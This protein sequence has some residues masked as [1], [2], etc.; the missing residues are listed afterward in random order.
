MSA[1]IGANITEKQREYHR[2]K[3]RTRL[4]RLDVNN[5]GKVNAK[6]FELISDRIITLGKLN[7]AQ[8]KKI[9]DGLENSKWASYM[10]F[11][12]GIALTA[13]QCSDFF[14]SRTPEQGLALTKEGHDPIFDVIDTDDDGFITM[15]EFKVFLKSG[16]PALTDEEMEHSFNT[17]DKNKNKQISRD[18]FIAAAKDFYYGVEETELSR[19]FMGKLVD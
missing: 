12:K 9:R 4:A 7:E 16:C 11:D 8:A 15:D 2:Q 13:V 18:E 17:L 6:D 3:M 10:D 1:A 5:D 14:L 19:V